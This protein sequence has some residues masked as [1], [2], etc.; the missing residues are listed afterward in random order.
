[1]INKRQ[2]LV[3]TNFEIIRQI[4]KVTFIAVFHKVSVNSIE[5]NGKTDILSKEMEAI[6]K[7]SEHF[8]NENTIY[9]IKFHR[10]EEI[11]DGG[12]QDGSEEECE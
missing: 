5:M 4:F 12:G 3:D 8:R 6:N 2:P 10:M 1:M 9:E 7:I 11:Q